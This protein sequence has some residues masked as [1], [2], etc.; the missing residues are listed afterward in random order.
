[1]NLG[2]FPIGRC[3]S[4]PA[5]ALMKIVGE[6]V[7]Q[8]WGDVWIVEYLY[9]YDGYYEHKLVPLLKNSPLEVWKEIPEDQF[10]SICLE[11]EVIS[12]GEVIC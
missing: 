1:M 7:I 5:G 2:L 4:S 10:N 8:F 12:L 11:G 3:F 9:K 6:A